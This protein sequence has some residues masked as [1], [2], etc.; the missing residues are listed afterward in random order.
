[1]SSWEHRS[2]LANVSMIRNCVRVKRQIRFKLLRQAHSGAPHPSQ[3]KEVIILLRMPQFFE[4][5]LQ[6]QEKAVPS[7]K[8]F[9][10]EIRDH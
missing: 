10:E 3:K 2:T 9:P 8:L 5:L 4:H 7:C 6:R 1:M